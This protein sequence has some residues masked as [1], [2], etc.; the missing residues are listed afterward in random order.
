MAV[1]VFKSHKV[2]HFLPGIGSADSPVFGR[3]ALGRYG[4]TALHFAAL[5]S[6]EEVLSCLLEA[7][8]DKAWW[9]GSSGAAAG[10]KLR[11][12]PANPPVQLN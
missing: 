4:R 10:T 12:Q 2:R 9:L 8:A 1:S 3:A 7:K 6:R 11:V 5:Q